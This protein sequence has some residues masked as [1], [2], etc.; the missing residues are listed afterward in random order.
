MATK[1]ATS[2]Q[3]LEPGQKPPSSG[4][5]LEVGPQGGKVSKP[6]QVSITPDDGHLPPTS[7]KGNNW[8]KLK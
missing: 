1:K 8:R 4:E 6:R 3:M 5:Y 7:K 2:N